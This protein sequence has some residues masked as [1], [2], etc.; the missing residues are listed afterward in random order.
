MDTQEDLTSVPINELARREL[1]SVQH[2][3]LLRVYKP[4]WLTDPA[5]KERKT[6][7]GFTARNYERR[8]YGYISKDAAARVSERGFGWDAIFVN[9]AT[10]LTNEQYFAEYGEKICKRTCGE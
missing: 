5:N 7:T 9:A 4:Q 3:S 6:L 1:E 8:A 10:N 2:T